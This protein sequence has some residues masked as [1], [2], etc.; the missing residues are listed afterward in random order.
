MDPHPSADA[1][2]QV[3]TWSLAVYFVVVAVVAFLLWQTLLA[4]RAVRQ[5]VSD[6][7]TV[8]QKVANNTIHIALLRR[9]NAVAGQILQA[10]VKVVDATDAIDK[11]AHECPGCPACVLGPRGA[12]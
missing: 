5:G 8:G 2:A 10:A 3:W 9:T 4:A 11:H 1:V 6:I 12:R 7:W